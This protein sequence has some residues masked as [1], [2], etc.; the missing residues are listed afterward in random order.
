MKVISFS[1]K[2][3]IAKKYENEIITRVLF[4]KTFD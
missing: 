1:L 2:L 3:L 4:T